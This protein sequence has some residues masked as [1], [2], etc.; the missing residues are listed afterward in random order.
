M[1]RPSLAQTIY[2]SATVTV[3]AFVLLLLTQT[4]SSAVAVL[5]ATIAL[6][7]GVLVALVL[8]TTGP[9][10]EEVTPQAHQ[11]NEGSSPEATPPV[12]SS[13]T[14]P[15]TASPPGSTPAVPAE[16]SDPA[17]AARRAAPTP[18]ERATVEAPPVGVRG[19]ELAS[20]AEDRVPQASFR[21]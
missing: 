12:R 16:Q 8:S 5:I 17:E 19:S 11:Q 1:P 21:H 6:L 7:L 18:A 13:E 10:G 15:R 9:T 14:P 3:T 20:T 4:G 2:G